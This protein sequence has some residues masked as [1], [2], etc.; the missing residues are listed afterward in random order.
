M[1]QNKALLSVLILLFLL[2][3]PPLILAKARPEASPKAKPQQNE[4]YT[5]GVNYDNY[6]A[7]YTDESY[8]KLWQLIFDGG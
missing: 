3:H 7:E 5:N 1:Y 2:T 6:N 4:D 8:G